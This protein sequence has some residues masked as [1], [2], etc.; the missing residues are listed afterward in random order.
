MHVTHG[1]RL[2]EA[3]RELGCDWREILD[4]SASIN[5]LGPAPGVR[6]A[7]VAAL[8]EIVHYPDP[9]GIRLQHALAEQWRV[10]PDCILVGNGA[11]EL[12]HFV[13]RVWRDKV[14]LAVPVF[15]EFHRAFPDAS[16]VPLSADWPGDGLLV[17]T[18]PVNPSGEAI[19][20]RDRRDLTWVDESFIEFT[21]LPSCL[22][23]ALVLRSLTKFHALPG[24]RIGALVGPVDLMRQWRERREPWQLNVLAEAAALVAIQAHQHHIRTREYVRAERERVIASIEQLLA[25]STRPSLANYITIQVPSGLSKDIA[26]QFRKRHILVR[27][28]TGWP[29][30]PDGCLRIAIRTREENDRLLH[31]WTEIVGHADW[32][33]C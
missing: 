22:G 20:F 25:G 7:I 23:R 18:N 31:C 28:C 3:A 24:L 1:G 8:D 2:F 30:V 33:S 5:P 32:S 26:E 15:S 11:T 27:D 12:I 10:E 16:L 19:D 13:S 6:D 29:G 14:T 17:Y 4:F 21:D 9:Y